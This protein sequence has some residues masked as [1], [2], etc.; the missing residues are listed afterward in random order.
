MNVKKGWAEL[1]VAENN[2]PLCNG[3]RKFTSMFE[4]DRSGSEKKKRM[5]MK[6][7]M[8]E[9]M[10]GGKFRPRDH[11]SPDLTQLLNAKVPIKGGV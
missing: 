4:T 5:K 11:F 3:P 9:W 7:E 2:K 10:I 8:N 1:D 6:I